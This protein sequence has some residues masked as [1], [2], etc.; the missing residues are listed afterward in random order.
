[1]LMTS[2]DI[3][4]PLQYADSAGIRNTFRQDID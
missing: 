2:G 4:K 3:P 1:M